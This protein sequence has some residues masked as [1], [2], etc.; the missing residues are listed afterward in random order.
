MSKSSAMGLSS[1]GGLISGVPVGWGSLGFSGVGVGCGCCGTVVG[2]G[3]GVAVGCGDWVSLF[4]IGAAVGGTDVG[5]LLVDWGRR[6][7]VGVGVIRGL[8]AN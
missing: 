3:L 7:M 1:N 2:S 4:A 8:E 6:F 5:V